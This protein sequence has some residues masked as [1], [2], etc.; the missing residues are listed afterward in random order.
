M[1]NANCQVSEIQ[2]ISI[3]ASLRCSENGEAGVAHVSESGL[4]RIIG[5]ASKAQP[6]ELKAA[7]LAFFCNFILLAS[8]YILRPLRDTMATVF[9]VAQLQNL[10][11]AT[12]VLTLLLAPIFA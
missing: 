3:P 1:K 11:T 6:H 9:G 12:F 7:T 10:F 4:L 8:Y 2:A 5:T